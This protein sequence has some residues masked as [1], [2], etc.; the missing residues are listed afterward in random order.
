MFIAARLNRQPDAVL[1]KCKR[2]KLKLEVVVAKPYN[3]TTTTR[4]V[5]PKE[6]PSV[7]EA[8]MLGVFWRLLV[9]LGL[10]RLRF[11]VCGVSQL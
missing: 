6:L 9:C 8:L 5:L 10:T 2:F 7:G 11:H 1:I 4:L 3:P